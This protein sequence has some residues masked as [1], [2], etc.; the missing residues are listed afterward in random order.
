MSV[1]PPPSGTPTGSVTFKDSATNIAGCVNVARELPATCTTSSLGIGSHSITA[2]YGGDT[3]FN[4][5]TSP[6]VNQVVI[7][8]NAVPVAASQ[9]VTTDEDTAKIVTL[10]DRCRRQRVAFSI[11]GNPAHGS[12]AIT[13]TACSGIP[14]SCTASVTYTPAADYNGPDSFTFKVNDGTADP[15]AATLSITVNAVNDP[16]TFD[17]IAD[18]TVN[19]DAGTQNVS[20]TGVSAGRATNRRRR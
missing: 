18:Q 13:G 19:E 1:V 14:S 5:S 6:V 17:A 8:A 11:V 16:P 10:G 20:I 3:T 9:S 12:L 2:V 7:I 15:N 4:G